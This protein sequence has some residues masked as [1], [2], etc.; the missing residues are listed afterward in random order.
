[1]KRR[2]ELVD[3][4]RQ[5]YRWYSTWAVGASSLL[6]GAW[7]AFPDDLKAALPWWAVTAYAAVSFLA[8]LGARAVKQIGGGK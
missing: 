3:D 1:M 2:I 8:F 5:F 7:G 4:A 6:L